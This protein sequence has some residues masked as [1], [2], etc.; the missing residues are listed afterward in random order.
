MDTSGRNQ[1]TNGFPVILSAMARNMLSLSLSLSLKYSPP[2]RF[3]RDNSAQILSW[4]LRAASRSLS[5]RF[6]D[7]GLPAAVWARSLFALSLKKSIY[8]ELA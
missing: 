5:S 2:S 6:S 3:L 7:D 8:K 1:Q 4:T